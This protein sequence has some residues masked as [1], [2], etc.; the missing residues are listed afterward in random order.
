LPDLS[1]LKARC[2]LAYPASDRDC[3]RGLDQVLVAVQAGDGAGSLLYL[4]AVQRL[5]S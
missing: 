5:L 1:L 3:R 2:A 4:R